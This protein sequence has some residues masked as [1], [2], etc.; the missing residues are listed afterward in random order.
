MSRLLLLFLLMRAHAWPMQLQF[1]TVVT[2]PALAPFTAGP[3]F[4]YASSSSQLW[5]FG[6]HASRR[7]SPL[8]AV[9][10][11]CGLI[12]AN[13]SVFLPSSPSG[14]SARELCSLA[15]AGQ[16]LLLYGGR[17]S[18]SLSLG[19][20]WLFSASRNQWEQL[21]ASQG[22]PSPRYAGVAA[23]L[24]GRVYLHGGLVQGQLSSE[25][26]VFSPGSVASNSTWTL[27]STA[28][29][30]ASH[31][32]LV[33]V[34]TT[35]RLFLFAQM[36]VY[37]IT[38]IGSTGTGLIVDAL[39]TSPVAALRLPSACILNGQ[40]VAG[41]G[42]DPD[43]GKLS[44]TLYT[45]NAETGVLMGSTEASGVPARY[46]ASLAC[47]SDANTAWIAGGLGAQGPLTDI[48][49]LSA[50]FGTFVAAPTGPAGRRDHTASVIGSAV[51]IFGGRNAD[52]A[53][54][55]FWRFDA[56]T[57]SWTELRPAVR[58]CRR[59][60]HSA[61]STQDGVGS[62]VIFIFGG[63]VSG[64]TV[65]GDLW[66][67][68]APLG[69]W[70]NILPACP[71]PRM[72]HATV[73]TR[74]ATGHS[75]LVVFGGMGDAGILSDVWQLELGGITRAW[76]RLVG[77]FPSR[78]PLLASVPPNSANS[79][80]YES[81]VAYVTSKSLASFSL[82]A[83]ALE[84]RVWD[85]STAPVLGA[86]IIAFAGAKTT[87][88]LAAGGER[89]GRARQAATAYVVSA[90]GN[91]STTGQEVPMVSQTVCVHQA[92][93]LVPDGRLL[94]FGGSLVR[95]GSNETDPSLTSAVLQQSALC[96]NGACDD[97]IAGANLA[98]GQ[99][100][101][102]EQGSFGWNCSGKCPFGF[103]TTSRGAASER[104]CLPCPEGTY[105]RTS[106]G[107]ESCDSKP[108]CDGFGS[109]A[110]TLVA[111]PV[112]RGSVAV[113]VVGATGETISPDE[114]QNNARSAANGALLVGAGVFA[115][116]NLALAIG[117]CLA[118][119]R[120]RR[121][122]P[123]VVRC[124]TRVDELQACH[125]NRNLKAGVTPLLLRRTFWGG[126]L[127]V[128]CSIAVCVL[129]VHLILWYGPRQAR[130][131]STLAPLDA[132]SVSNSATLRAA[133]ISVTATFH[134][135]TSASHCTPCSAAGAS[136]TVVDGAF[137]PGGF[138]QQCTYVA[139]PQ[140][141]CNIVWQ[142]SACIVSKD[143]AKLRF[144]LASAFAFANAIAVRIQTTSAHALR[145]GSPLRAVA[146][147]ATAAEI[148]TVYR[149]SSNISRVYI[150]LIQEYLYHTDASVSFGYQ[151]HAPMVEV[152]AQVPAASSWFHLEAAGVAVEVLVLPKHDVAILWQKSSSETP[153]ALI[154]LFIGLFGGGAVL[155]GLLLRWLEWLWWRTTKGTPPGWEATGTASGTGARDGVRP[156]F[157]DADATPRDIVMLRAE[158]NFL[159]G[160]IAALQSEVHPALGA[161]PLYWN[162]NFPQ[163]EPTETEE[164]D[165]PQPSGRVVVRKIQNSD[166]EPPSAST[167]GVATPMQARKRRNG[168]KRPAPRAHAVG[169]PAPEPPSPIVRTMVELGP[170]DEAA[171][172]VL[173][174]P[175]L[176]DAV[177]VPPSSPRSPLA[178]GLVNVQLTVPAQIR[179][180][181]ENPDW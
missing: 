125:L 39:N 136:A 128:W 21:P 164:S 45:F 115:A 131:S 48:W 161:V 2:S 97:C 64:S 24:G 173:A 113:Q 74:S 110:A 23:T 83:V 35:G 12:A 81:T 144:Q 20:T 38:P 26:W 146:T 9:L 17:D 107:C 1:T 179:L 105:S 174:R 55:D 25:M 67:W 172:P 95:Q 49:R 119:M 106:T 123:L 152:G 40:V 65:L 159:K 169:S 140:Q 27:A 99:C 121:S 60:S 104:F 116:V 112:S 71:V 155:T 102:C 62:P 133:T 148:G 132:I 124:L 98:A 117:Y 154:A 51:F 6:G 42:L 78:T 170:P 11:G 89:A 30:A 126:L 14:P 100:V 127:S 44:A 13:C 137:L 70:E 153:V 69:L 166:A 160:E 162:D 139:A 118:R 109:T 75:R 156:L 167:S 177:P 142:C 138:S 122:S 28:L 145:T 29:P 47:V 111:L 66:L 120:S 129:V 168:T 114:R 147:A 143:G 130:W 180:V 31:H 32:A 16:A 150:Q 63:A 59:Y 61:T 54:D 151:L 88:I 84:G 3:G 141:Q 15:D 178:P 92:A 94:L 149:G 50:V 5:G 80:S 86:S 175:S 41:L 19:D 53:L 57:N 101:P 76:L 165:G 171:A 4:C 10:F 58:P 96:A 8:S 87:W 176:E 46:G 157:T 22:G 163:E 158:I 79:L 34:A 37:R 52:G 33:A 18:S 135:V 77:T 90:L 72:R 85:P 181:A 36:R 73:L 56:S 91:Q 103:F 82:S 7:E 93:A 108:A 43:T 134:G 68:D